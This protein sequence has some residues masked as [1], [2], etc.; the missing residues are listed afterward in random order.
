[1]NPLRHVRASL[2]AVLSGRSARTCATKILDQAVVTDRLNSRWGRLFTG[3]SWQLVLDA[4]PDGSG[5]A[6]L[7]ESRPRPADVRPPGAVDAPSPGALSEPKTA[8]AYYHH[9]Q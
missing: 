4:G 7:A 9:A 1:M 6:H 3:N 5:A 8:K 2:R